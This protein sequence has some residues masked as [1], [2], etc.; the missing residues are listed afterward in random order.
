[1]FNKK[2]NFKIVKII[3]AM[4]ILFVFCSCSNKTK[5]LVSTQNEILNVDTTYEENNNDIV[6]EKA[7]ADATA[8]EIALSTMSDIIIE[9][10]E[11][12]F[13]IE[14][15]EYNV[16]RDGEKIMQWHFETN[17]KDGNFIYVKEYIGL[18]FEYFV[19][20]KI[21]DSEEKLL[22][23]IGAVDNVVY[24]NLK[25]ENEEKY[26]LNLEFSNGGQEIIL[27]KTTDEPFDFGMEQQE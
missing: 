12:A 4:F 10:V 17:N 24:G 20:E 13:Y 19:I 21:N 9:P 22:F 8:S 2:N 3:I 26:I 1:M 7:I 27:E 23:H 6:S 11:G 15:G 5:N 25:Q 16:Y 18:G 14:P